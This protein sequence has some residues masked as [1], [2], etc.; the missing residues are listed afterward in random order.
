MNCDQF[1]AN[2]ET[3][4]LLQRMRARRHIRRCPHCA[5]VYATLTDLKRQ[6]A[7]TE[8]LSPELRRLWEQAATNDEPRTPLHASRRR[9][10]IVVAIAASA[11]CLLIGSWFAI[12]SPAPKQ[13]LI[14]TVE[15]PA[16]PTAPQGVTPAAAGAAELKDLSAAVDRLEVEL[17]ELRKVAERR[18]IEGKVAVV[19]KRFDQW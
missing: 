14:Q 16:R 7:S 6:L 19:L 5:R 9:N 18:D 1:L 8:E 17:V 15:V 3:G 10:R 4:G 11:A 13:S 12:R 2:L